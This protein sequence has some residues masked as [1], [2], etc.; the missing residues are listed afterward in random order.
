VNDTHDEVRQ[1]LNPSRLLGVAS[2]VP[3]LMPDTVTIHPTLVALLN[4]PA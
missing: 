3:K 2:S 4:A 1:M